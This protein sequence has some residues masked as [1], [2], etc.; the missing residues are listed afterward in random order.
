MNKY[1]S[2]II[3]ALGIGG[4]L[5]LTS[6]SEPQVGAGTKITLEAPQV[7]VWDKPKT[8]AEWAEDVKKENFDIKSTGKLTEMRD[9]HVEKLAL[10]EQNMSEIF[11][12]RECVEYRARKDNPTWSEIDI[13][14]YYLQELSKAN[15]EVEKLKQSIERM[16]KELE[17]RGK[18]FVLV[19]GEKTG[20]F[21]S[22][23]TPYAVRKI[24]D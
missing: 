18:G 2:L 14:N 22:I 21:G 23:G 24:N 12:C 9:V 5:Y 7:V 8:D 16:E 11:D 10:V 20:L 6:D 13:D 4:S 15:W 1:T 3:L 17:L 19:E